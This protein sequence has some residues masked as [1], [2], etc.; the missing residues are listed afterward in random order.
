[1]FQDA[2]CI[3]AEPQHKDNNA[4]YVMHAFYVNSLLVYIL[5]NIYSVFYFS[6]VNQEAF[7][8]KIQ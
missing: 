4:E 7:V 1:M 3:T 5:N 8:W 6:L 2:N